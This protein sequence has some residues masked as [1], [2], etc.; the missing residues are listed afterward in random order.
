MQGVEGPVESGRLVGS[1]RNAAT[2]MSTP[3]AI[4]ATPLRTYPTTP[5]TVTVCS[6][7]CRGRTSCFQND[8]RAPSITRAMPMPTATAATSSR[9]N[10]PPGVAR[11]LAAALRDEPL[12]LVPAPI[13][14]CIADTEIAPYTIALPAFFARAPQARALSLRP[15]T[16]ASTTSRI[17]SAAVPIATTQSR[18]TP[19]GTRS[20]CCSAPDWSVSVPPA[21]LPMPSRTTR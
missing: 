20:I 11:A 14:Y 17:V 5:S 13:A 16:T 7:G 6:I 10:T 18:K 2:A 3:T 8:R 15:P 21:A 19:P 4:T 12:E 1:L 9:R